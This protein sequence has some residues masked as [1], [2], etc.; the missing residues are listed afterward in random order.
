M[1][2]HRLTLAKLNLDSFVRYTLGT[3][4]SY[5][6]VAKGLLTFLGSL[7]KEVAKTTSE[8]LVY[9]FERQNA[10]KIFL[11]S[12]NTVSSTKD[13]GFYLRNLQIVIFHGK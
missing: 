5:G 6:V 2:E 12:K 7:Y 3:A 9:V 8:I 13:V 1:I 10:T 11:P 4:M